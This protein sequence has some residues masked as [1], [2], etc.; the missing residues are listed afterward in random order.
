MNKTLTFAFFLL[1]GQFAFAQNSI[2][3]FTISGQIAAPQSYDSIYNKKA[4]EKVLMVNFVAP[5][6]L[7]DKTIWFNGLNYL[8]V[9]IDNEEFHSEEMVNSIEI[10]GLI[11]RTGIIRKLDEN[12]SLQVLFVPRMMS[13]MKNADSRNFQFGGFA[14]YQ[15]KFR[16]NL[17]VG[18]GIN[19]SQELSGPFISPIVNLNWQISERWSITG[20]LPINSK[21]SYHYNKDFS[22][23]FFHQGMTTTYNLTDDAYKDDYI[24]RQNIEAGLFAKYRLFGNLNAEG[25]ISQT[26]GRSYAQ[27]DRDEK[28]DISLPLAKFGDDRE[29]KNVTFQDGVVVNVRLVYS[30]DLVN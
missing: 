10:H 3:L 14:L 5:V 9:C 8:S 25:R 2:D 7:S 11:F 15:K 22:L 20:L 30:L 29:M 18:F 4:E 27:Y 16:D 1:I 13:D 26:F 28:I 17:S 6:K 21:V 23:G 12:R 19:Y 24:E